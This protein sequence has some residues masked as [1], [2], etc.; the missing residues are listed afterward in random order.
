[1]LNRRSHSAVE[2][3]RASRIRAAGGPAELHVWAG[4]FR[5]FGAL[6]PQAH[7]SATARRTG[8]PDSCP[9]TP[10]RSAPASPTVPGVRPPGR[11]MAVVGE[12]ALAPTGDLLPSV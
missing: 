8:S 5:G 3:D 2:E 12:V 9:R 4:G 11:G 1:M 10:P 6:C 7:I